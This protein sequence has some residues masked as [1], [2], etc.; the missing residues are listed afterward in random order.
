MPDGAEDLLHKRIAASGLWSRRKAQTLIQE[1]RV[2]VDGETI[3]NKA[4]RVVSGASV[5]VDG[6]K[7]EAAKVRYLVLNKP[8]GYVTTLS[9]PHARRTVMELLEGVNAKLKPVGRLD[10]DTEGLLLFTNDG[11]LAARLTH[12]RYGI[13]KEYEVTVRGEIPEDTFARLEKG[14]F[15]EGGKTAPAAIPRSTV[16]LEERATTFHLVI[17]EGRKHQVRLMCLAV[18][19]PVKKLRRMRVG[20]IVLKGLPKGA[21]RFLDAKEVEALK[22]AV[23]MVV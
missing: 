6:R 5:R 20:P 4:A 3:L 14:V 8:K 16:R 18:G 10:K 13:E 7:V 22:R 9:D 12:P 23:G 11:E 1:G 15:I 19:F 17:H 2:T 21:C